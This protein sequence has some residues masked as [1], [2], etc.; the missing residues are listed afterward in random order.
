MSMKPYVQGAISQMHSAVADVDAQFV[1]VRQDI[2][3]KK[4]HLS[5]QHSV[6]EQERRLHAAEMNDLQDD[7]QRRAVQQRIA[8][9][10]KELADQKNQIAQMDAQLS[11]AE[12]Q[13]NSLQQSLNSAASSLNGLLSLPDIR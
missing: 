7:G 4:S 12:Q 11:Q 13:K 3:S 1:S 6:L 8:A 2:N 10:D 5:S 9:I